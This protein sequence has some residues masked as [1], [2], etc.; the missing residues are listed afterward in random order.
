MAGHLTGF[1]TSD[2]LDAIAQ[3]IDPVPGNPYGPALE[4]VDKVKAR[5]VDEVVTCA[6]RAEAAR[7]FGA[8]IVAMQPA[9]GDPGVRYTMNVCRRCFLRL[10]NLAAD[11]EAPQQV[12]SGRAKLEQLNKLEAE[13]EAELHAALM[14]SIAP[15]L[16]KL[17]ERHHELVQQVEALKKG[18]GVLTRAEL[19]VLKDALGADAPKGI[20]AWAIR[21][22]ARE[23]VEGL[24]EHAGGYLP[25]E[26]RT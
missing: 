3:G 11:L 13:L 17:R 8:V 1:I 24:L 2:E 4:L 6:H 18:A 23:L 22:R 14:Q 7:P 15:D 19:S 26:E 9:P 16:R 5:M 25:R 20:D 21:G 10:G 12:R